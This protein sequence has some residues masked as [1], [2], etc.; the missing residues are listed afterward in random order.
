MEN[1][2]FLWENPL[3]LW[4]FSIILCWFQQKPAGG[5]PHLKAKES[6]LEHPKHLAWR[7]GSAKLEEQPFRAALS[8]RK[9][10]EDDMYIYIYYMYY[11]YIYYTYNYIY[12]YLTLVNFSFS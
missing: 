8:Q 1:H 7:F 9:N 4:P 5:I 6:T 3:F 12:S 10:A 2:H 11:I